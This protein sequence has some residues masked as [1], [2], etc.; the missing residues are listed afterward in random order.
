MVKSCEKTGKNGRKILN[1]RHIL[2]N[3]LFMNFTKTDLTNRHQNPNFELQR[4]I[5]ARNERIPRQLVSPPAAV[6]GVIQKAPFACR[7][8]LWN[9]RVGVCLHKYLPSSSFGVTKRATAIKLLRLL[10]M[11]TMQVNRRYN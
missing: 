7:V 3:P 9:A 4:R 5:E 10:R 11:R 1:P 6:L 8:G 2:R